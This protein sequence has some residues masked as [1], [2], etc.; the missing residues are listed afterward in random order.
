MTDTQPTAT[1]AMPPTGKGS[2]VLVLHA[3]WGLNETMRAFCRRLA[4]I[5]FVAFTPDLYH[6][7]VTDSIAGA[8][9]P[10]QRTVRKHR[11]GQS[12]PGR[13]DADSQQTRRSV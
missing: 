6:G 1:L 11:P 10:E 2:A 13:G 9:N 3:W 8:G 5:G 12:R 7:K 4:E